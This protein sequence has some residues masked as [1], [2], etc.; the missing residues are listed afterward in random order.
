MLESEREKVCATHNFGVEPLQFVV[1]PAAA[2][3]RGG[4]GGGGTVARICG[5]GSAAA[6]SELLDEVHDHFGL[7]HRVRWRFLRLRRPT[8]VGIGTRFGAGV[9]PPCHGYFETI[10]Y[11][12]HSEI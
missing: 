8:A 2:L 9:A 7:G 6:V 5:G 11:L 10:S 3:L 4:G 12:L 1:E